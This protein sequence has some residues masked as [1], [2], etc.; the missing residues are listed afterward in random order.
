MVNSTFILSVNYSLDSRESKRPL[1]NSPNPSNEGEDR[2]YETNLTDEYF[3]ELYEAL[4]VVIE[5]S[6]DAIGAADEIDA[7]HAIKF[8]KTATA[9]YGSS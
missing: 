4:A 9:S 5:G 6:S 2:A 1:K 3:R 7:Q 8:M